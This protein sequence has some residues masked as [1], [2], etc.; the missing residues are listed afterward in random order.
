MAF[1]FENWI[2]KLAS[3]FQKHKASAF[4]SQFCECHE[5]FA[6]KAPNFEAITTLG[7]WVLVVV[8]EYV[9]VG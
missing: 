9:V 4:P 5:Q 8:K 6:Y 1:P 2:L 7:F 3:S